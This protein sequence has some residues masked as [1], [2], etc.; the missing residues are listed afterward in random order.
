MPLLL[1]LSFG[2]YPAAVLMNLTTATTL[3]PI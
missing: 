2:L 3:V 1:L